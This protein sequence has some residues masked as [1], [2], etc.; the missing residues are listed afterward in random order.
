MSRRSVLA[1]SIVFAASFV[2]ADDSPDIDALG[3][4]AGAWSVAADDRLVEE[5]WMAPAGGTMIGAGRTV[6]GDKTKFF[7]FLR[8]VEKDGTLVYIASPRG[9]ATTEFAMSQIGA[10]SVTF[11]NPK[12]DFPQKITYRRDADKLCAR[13]EGEGEPAEEWCYSPAATR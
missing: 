13:V 3:W 4:M 12:H 9:G 2:L 8:I 11:A 6:N 5:I 1:L 7:E 10:S